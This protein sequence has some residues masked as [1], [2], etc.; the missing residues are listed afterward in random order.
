MS[1]QKWVNIKSLN[2][3]FMDQ[4]N[5]YAAIDVGS[6]AVR[7]LLA[8]LP[9]D[10]SDM[11][12]KKLSRMRMPIRL[13]EDAFVDRRISD[14][15]IIRLEKTFTGFQYLIDAFQPISFMACATSA[16]RTARNGRQICERI[17]GKTGIRIDI[18]DGKQEARIL[19]KN[20]HSIMLS[21]QIASLFIDVGGGSTEIT[22]FFQGRVIASRSFNIGT[23]RLLENMGNISV[24]E[25]M[26]QWLKEKTAPYPSVEAIGTGGNIN[27]LFRLANG[28]KNIP[29]SYKKILQINTMLKKST[30]EE[31]IEAFGLRPDRADVIVPGSYIYLQ[32]MK[33]SG[34]KKFMCPCSVLPMA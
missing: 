28:K 10:D 4:I 21:E 17:L 30:I 18:I 20:K 6:N 26:H 11:P 32:A 25:T 19:F 24:W 29:L 23:I 5:K 13:G 15:K 16:M 8:G 3:P 22:L 12:P 2:R 14:E 34:C 27:K 7:L 31:R 1:M 9:D 33:W